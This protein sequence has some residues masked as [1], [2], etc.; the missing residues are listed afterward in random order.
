MLNRGYQ[1]KPYAYMLWGAIVGYAAIPKTLT[2]VINDNV[3]DDVLDQ[4]LFSMYKSIEKSV[5]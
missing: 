1:L 3:K 5:Q 2:A 4:Y